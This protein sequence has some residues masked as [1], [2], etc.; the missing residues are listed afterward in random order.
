MRLSPPALEIDD[1]QGF[2]KSD[3]F[4]R[5]QF[6]SGLTALLSRVSDPV[7]MALDAPW[8]AG[9]TVFLKMWAGELRKQGFPV[10]YFDAFEHDFVDDCF[11]ALA[12][13]VIAL[14]DS[15]KERKRL[16]DLVSAAVRVSKVLARSGLKLGVKAATLGALDLTD[17]GD[18]AKDIS[19]EASAVAD[20]YFGEALTKQKEQREIIA[21]FKSALS[22]IPEALAKAGE[23]NPKRPLVFIIDELD[24][25]RPMFAL[26][27][28]ERVKHFFSVPNVHFV[29]GVNQEQ[30]RV[31]IQSAYGANIDANLYLQKFIHVT[32]FLN[33]AA[34]RN[35]RTAISKYVAYLQKAMDFDP[36]HSATV[37][38]TS[39]SIEALA[40]NKDLSLRTVERVFALLALV[41]AF[42]PK[43]LQ[44]IPALLGG[45]C[46]MKVLEPSLFKKAKRGELKF[47]DAV[48]FL[49]GYDAQLDWWRFATGTEMDKE[50]QQ[51]YQRAIFYF[52]FGP[53]GLL[54]FT[55]N[56]IDRVQLGA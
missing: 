54:P 41:V 17:L 40:V 29:L 38:Y 49:S 33:D 30:L 16:E 24:R 44:K 8:G 52:S 46:V 23:E 48:R 42:T 27:L 35:E 10:V 31:S 2:A 19:A 55:A 12:G 20:K 53:E 7:V 6:A 21:R 14:G 45:L 22:A 43:G 1:E 15:L 56:L 28:L 5:A 9:K 50:L 3:L 39:E 25:C 47:E 26:E 11:T 37:H 18:A 51:E 13:E 34:D 4:G 36:E 32:F